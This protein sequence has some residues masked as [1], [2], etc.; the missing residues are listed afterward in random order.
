MLGP[1]VLSISATMQRP[2]SFTVTGSY[3]CCAVLASKAERRVTSIVNLTQVSKLQLFE[4]CLPL[5]LL[6]DCFYIA[7]IG[8]GPSQH[9]SASTSISL[10]MMHAI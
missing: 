8:K 4:V 1:S 10:S 3:A 7:N 9:V 2:R 6:Y 5:L